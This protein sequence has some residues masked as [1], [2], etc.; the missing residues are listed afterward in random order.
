MNEHYSQAAEALNS[1]KR[2]LITT[3]MN[4]DGD[5]AGSALGLQHAMRS[6]GKEVT[7]L[8][9]TSAPDNLTW[10]PGSEGMQVWYGRP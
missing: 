2:V 9:P 4:P 10:M 8:L 7:V 1:S 5:A 3:H 6:M